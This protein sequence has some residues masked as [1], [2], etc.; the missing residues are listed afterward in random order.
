MIKAVIFDFDNTL[1]DFMRAKRAAVE[2]AA[3]AMVD[4][5]LDM[6]KERM[7]EKIYKVYD[8]EGIEDQN[9]FD[10]VLTQEFGKINYKIL[11]AG[12][13]GYRRAKQGHMALYPHVHIALNDLAKMGIKMVVVS[14]A[15]RLQVWMRVVQMGIQHYF[16][17]V[18]SF[19]D[20]GEKKP[21]PKPFRRALEILGVE[22]GEV[23]MI[24]DWA[25]RDMV[26]A[27][28]V[29]MRTCFARYGD[30]FNTKASGADY[31]IN[32]VLELVNIVRRENGGAPARAGKRS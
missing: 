1:M 24:G 21:S 12:I 9:V 3:E 25:E 2:A 11:A 30:E 23:I 8:K 18:V 20:T 5:G 28:A 16:D 26:G 7:V 14:D 29:G 4:S 6:P 15:P 32:D 31:E 27:K 17:D 19:D 22:A 13:V 10:K